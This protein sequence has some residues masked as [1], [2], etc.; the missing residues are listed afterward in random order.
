MNKRILIIGITLFI[1]IGIVFLSFLYFK[2]NNKFLDNSS[3][4]A[5]YLDD[6]KVDEIPAKGTGWA[7][8]NAECTNANG[9]WDNTR[10]GLK[11]S[12]ITG[13]VV[14]NINFQSSYT[15]TVNL[16]G[17]ANAVIAYTDLNGNQTQTLDSTGTKTG[18]EINLSPDATSLTLED[19][20]IAKNPSNLSANYTKTVSVSQSTTDIYVMPDGYVMYWYGYEPT[21][22]K[23]YAYGGNGDT[24]SGGTTV[25]NKTESPNYYYQYTS[26]DSRMGIVTNSVR[27]NLGDYSTLNSIAKHN[28]SSD[29]RAFVCIIDSV[30]DNYNSLGCISYYNTESNWTYLTR[31]ISSVTSSG[32][33][34]TKTNRY[35]GNSRYIRVQAVWLS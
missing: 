32:Y 10:W 14:C 31:N 12:N 18:V 27:V 24:F 20:T 26:A 30:K 15:I 16:Y 33:V 28:P 1:L 19:T 23:A 7:F 34:M 4:M 29:A 13:K 21:T 25:I 6:Q 35:S 9:T 3:I 22:L 5:I 2:N 8:K 11:V 17:A